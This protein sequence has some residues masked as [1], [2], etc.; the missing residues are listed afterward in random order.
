MRGN[1]TRGKLRLNWIALLTALVLL[2]SAGT[3]FAEALPVEE[4]EE[5]FGAPWINGTV[6]GNLPDAVPDAVDDFYLNTNY[7]AIASL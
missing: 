3:A 1:E 2:L 6:V 4:A 7:E 5:P